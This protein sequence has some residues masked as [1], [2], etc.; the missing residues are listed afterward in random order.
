[1][2]VRGSLSRVSTLNYEYQKTLGHKL[3][4]FISVCGDT[5]KPIKKYIF[6]NFIAVHYFYI[7]TLTI[8]TSILLYPVHDARYIDILFISTGATTQGGLNTVNINQLS[9]YQQIIIYISCCIST[10]IA[11]HGMLA[12]VRLYWFERHFDGIRE[13]SKQ[14]FRMRRTRT[15]L[16]RELSKRQLTKSNNQTN[17]GR[18]VEDFQEKLFSGKMV[19]REENS[20]LHMS[21]SSASLNSKPDDNDTED[22]SNSRVRTEVFAKR[23]N[24]TDITPQDMYRSIMILRNKQEHEITG[25]ENNNHHST[26]PNSELSHND[27]TEDSHTVGGETSEEGYRNQGYDT[28]EDS[29]DNPL[30]SEH[31]LSYEDD[32]DEEEFPENSELNHDGDNSDNSISPH[33]TIRHSNNETTRA[34]PSIMFDIQKPPRRKTSQRIVTHNDLK[35]TR[36]SFV[37]ASKSK[38]FKRIHKGRKKIGRNLKRRLS[39]GSIDRANFD[40]CLSKDAEDY[41]ADNE[42]DDEHFNLKKISTIDEL[43]QAPDFQ[44]MIYKNWKAKHR[45][46]HPKNL[47]KKSLFGDNESSLHLDQL[48]RVHS[49][50]NANA[51]PTTSSYQNE[52]SFMHSD[53]ELNSL[54]TDNTD[55]YKESINLNHNISFQNDIDEE[56]DPYDYYGIHFDPNFNFQPKSSKVGKG[57]NQNKFTRTMSTNYL[58]WQ[59]TIARNSNFFGLTKQ[60]KEELGGIEY[61]ALK[62]LCRILLIYYFGFH[63]V[64]FVMM[65]PWICTK[66]DFIHILRSDG[67][68]P[69]WWGF[70]TPMSAFNN[71]GLTLTPDSMNSF[72]TAIYPLIVLMWFIIIGNTG[73]PVLLRFII[74][75]MFKISP[76][77]SQIKES[78]GFLLDHPRRCFTLLFPSAATWWLLLTLLFLNFTDW[79]LFIILDFG[80]SVVKVFSKGHRVLI[81]LFQAVC[82][83]TVGFSVIDLNKLHPAI[84]VSYMIMMYVSVL[85]LAISIRRTNVYEERALG[86]YS[87]SQSDTS[88]AEDTE[89]SD[90]EISDIES[91]SSTRNESS[92]T[93]EPRKKRKKKK[94]PATELSAKS[95]I[96]AHLRRQL[97]FDLWFLFLG[98]FIICICEDGKIRD[99]SKPDFNVFAI[100]FEVVSAYCT[101]GL[102]FGY[103]NTY[104]SLSAQFTTL[105]KLVIIALL[106]RGRNRGLPYSLDRAIILPSNRLD[107]IDHIEDLKLKNRNDT[108]T[109]GQMDPV[110]EYV[111]RHTKSFRQK[112]KRIITLGRSNRSN[113]ERQGLAE[114]YEL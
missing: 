66:K 112:F 103:T 77:L 37:S 39:T 93:N 88:D 54:R 27:M 97:S 8:I 83:R 98:L 36:A 48:F 81:G 95:F 72:S 108:A 18:N 58:S 85:P 71:M 57:K 24:S 13:L 33:T 63:V 3:R 20:I 79:I 30:T 7:I 35:S 47:G 92:S 68:S 23:R 19:N 96:G 52:T 86:L 45:R 106:I 14:N 21:L 43:T 31:S 101:V 12:F 53:G 42:T 107:H 87:S 91:G 109:V 62:L 46:I 5:L 32:D 49:I 102:S 70:F 64:A 38:I 94:H 2:T 26:D 65:V 44:K 114:E 10:P 113:E 105:S 6:P 110:T 55:N 67:I 111:E 40:S 1:M 82:T 59:P 22:T 41:F 50:S 61:R 90:S 75:I 29:N 73:F 25:A 28:G 99:T 104:E 74:W 16:G 4:D 84:Q 34:G 76:D 80:S 100:L 51:N 11:I 15:I 17:F 56:Q 89:D 69:A 78:L 60:Q 9:L